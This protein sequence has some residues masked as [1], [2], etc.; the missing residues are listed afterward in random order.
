[1]SFENIGKYYKRE[2][3]L[4]DTGI[5]PRDSLDKS[6]HNPDPHNS[7]SVAPTVEKSDQEIVD[8]VIKELRKIGTK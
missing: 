7:I 1:M 2:V 4:M 6:I 5:F 3:S 8:N